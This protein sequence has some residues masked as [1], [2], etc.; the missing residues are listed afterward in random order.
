MGFSWGF[1]GYK[2]FPW[3]FCGISMGFPWDSIGCPWDFHGISMGFHG[4]SMGFQRFL[5]TLQTCVHSR[6]YTSLHLAD[7]FPPQ[8]WKNQFQC[9]LV[10]HLSFQKV[11]LP[12]FLLEP[13]NVPS[14]E[15]SVE[16]S[17]PETFHGMLQA[18]NIPWSVPGL[19]HSVESS[20]PGTSHRVFQAWN[21]LWN[22]PDLEHPMESSRPGT[23]CG[24]FQA[25]NI[26]WN[27]PGLGHSPPVC[28][29]THSEKSFDWPQ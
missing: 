20:S 6:L 25:Q 22:L 4:I 21:I 16:C 18:W 5:R 14:L 7:S 24:T 8:I 2:G 27:V 10:E 26:P 11:W 29:T 1:I 19:E 9:I 13:W 28:R 3:D 17:K 15:D 23:L 12:D